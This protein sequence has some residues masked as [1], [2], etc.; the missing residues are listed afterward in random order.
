MSVRLIMLHQTFADFPCEIQSREARILLFEFLDDAQALAVVFEAAVALHQFVLDNLAFMAEG[1]MAEVVRQGDGFRQ[2]FVQLQS[3]GDVAGDGCDFHGVRQPRAQMVAGAVEKDLGLVFQPSK[4]PRVDD[5]VAVALVMRPPVGRF[6][7]VFAAAR[8]GAELGVASQILPLQL[9]EF[10]SRAGHESNSERGARN[11]PS[12]ALVN[13]PAVPARARL[14][15]QTTGGWRP[16]SGC[17]GSRR[18][19]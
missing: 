17:S 15:A 12:G 14:S 4:R 11:G 13:L 18:R 16:Q 5:A 6:L 19:P 8:V 2:I 10:F 1:G 9:F 7:R 3:P